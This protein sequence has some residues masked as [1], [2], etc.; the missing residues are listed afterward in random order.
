M[1]PMLSLSSNAWSVCPVLKHLAKMVPCYSLFL[2][3]KKGFLSHKCKVSRGGQKLGMVKYAKEV[4]GEL[5][6]EMPT[7]TTHHNVNYHT[8]L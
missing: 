7:E 2:L 6:L 1:H 8:N 5:K 3:H 4:R